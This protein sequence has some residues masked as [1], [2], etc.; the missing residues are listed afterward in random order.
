M[1][2]NSLK[3]GLVILGVGTVLLLKSEGEAKPKGEPVPGK[4]ISLAGINSFETQEDINKWKVGEGVKL[5]QSTEHATDGKYSVKVTL[6]PNK[7]DYSIKL[8][9]MGDKG[10]GSGD[11]SDYAMFAFDIYNPNRVGIPLSVTIRDSK[12]TDRWADTWHKD[13][14]QE[15]FG[16][17]GLRDHPAPAPPD[18][19]DP[20]TGWIVDEHTKYAGWK[21]DWKLDVVTSNEFTARVS[22]LSPVRFMATEKPWPIDDIESVIIGFPGGAPQKEATFFLDNV[23]LLTREEASP[24]LWPVI[25]KMTG[26]RMINRKGELIVSK[27]DVAKVAGIGKVLE[28]KVHVSNSGKELKEILVT[29]TLFSSDA[30]RIMLT[31]QEL[32]SSLGPEE[33]KALD[34]SL[35]LSSFLPERDYLLEVKLYEQERADSRGPGTIPA[36]LVD[37]FF[38]EIALRTPPY[39]EIIIPFIPFY[40]NISFQTVVSSL[41]SREE[42]AVLEISLEKEGR[43]VKEF[44]LKEIII[45]PGEEKTDEHVFDVKGIKPGKYDLL[46]SFL[47]DKKVVSQTIKWVRIRG[48]FI[49]VNERDFN[50]VL[51]FAPQVFVPTFQGSDVFRL[52]WGPSHLTYPWGLNWGPPRVTHP[53]EF[54]LE[55][56][57]EHQVPFLICE[58]LTNAWELANQPYEMVRERMRGIIREAEEIGGENFLGVWLGELG[59]GIRAHSQAV[60]EQETRLGRANAYIKLIKQ[61]KEDYLGLPPG[62]LFMIGSYY[63]SNQVLDAE[64][65][66]NVIIKESGILGS[67]TEQISLTRGVARSF[68]KGYGDVIASDAI[69]GVPPHFRG[70]LFHWDIKTGRYN[71]ESK[72][73][74]EGNMRW[75]WSL[76]EMYK[77][78][79]ERY[80]NGVNYLMSSNEHP[81]HS[82]EMVFNF[83]DFVEKNPRGKDI[84]SGVAVLESKGNYLGKLQPV[85]AEEV[86]SSGSRDIFGLWR[87]LYPDNIPYKEE[88][89]FLYLNSFFPN[90]TDDNVLYKH[91]WTGTP[92]G[93]VDRIY[94]AMGLEDMRKYNA[95]IFMGFH[96]M[97]S[98]RKDFPDDLMKY[99]KDGGIVVLAA[100]Q[101]RD[102]NEEFNMSELK[103]FSGVSLS[104][105]SKL[106]IKDYV[107][108][109]EDSPFKI[110]RERYPIASEVKLK[111]E[112]EPWVY[113]V[114]SE[115]AKVIA[116]DSQNIPV[117]LLNKFGKGYVFLF[118]SPT[119]SMIPPV[120]KSPLISDVIDKVCRYK[121]LPVILSPENEDV[122]FLI[123]RTED[124]EATVF[125]MNHGEKPWEGDI[126]I[127]LARSGLS[128]EVKDKVSAKVCQGYKVKEINPEVVK[129]GDTLI[130]KSIRVE[131]DTSEP[132]SYSYEPR[133]EGPPAPYSWDDIL[134]Q[135]SKTFCSYTKASFALIRLGERRDYE[136]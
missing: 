76:E 86:S 70:G 36:L 42:K 88:M 28:G 92:Y 41:S 82:G 65:G 52:G 126:I 77:F 55:R 75:D 37:T 120:G 43:P 81:L 39:V 56:F 59:D 105:D 63:P 117:L 109:V 54:P 49:P 115:G 110:N 25:E 85:N 9:F 69:S 95:I 112:K 111:E 35:I 31:E 90:L 2:K 135:R 27:V 118:T 47:Q 94:P 72:A 14:I 121:P 30:A 119:L 116:T 6:L 91:W 21:G 124:K 106:K 3:V 53:W 78:R 132:T 96:R 15:G 26:V 60:A 7:T 130:I 74:M 93:A 61:Y 58:G 71:P 83:L 79:L 102:S 23:R 19:R 1:R 5:E 123:A 29:A 107:K 125:I 84:V 22:I 134:S 103:S 40:E 13:L 108:V 20:A 68:R 114:T 113:K 18:T 4:V 11:W 73:K 127:D 122:E 133:R 8:D 80:Y 32:T 87:W 104:P 45:N 136:N 97:D 101:I 51:Q 38:H 129:K 34:F 48:P 46:V 89:D 128:P 67:F 24:L 33:A 100:D 10:A 62:K 17:P 66:A 12:H 64:A 44:P 57:V 16:V 99:V 50:Y 98:V 131:G